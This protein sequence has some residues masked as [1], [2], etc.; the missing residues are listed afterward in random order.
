MHHTFEM[1]DGNAEGYTIGTKDQ[2][3]YGEIPLN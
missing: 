3:E 2:G 1:G